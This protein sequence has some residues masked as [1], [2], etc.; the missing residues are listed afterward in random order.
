[1]TDQVTALASFFDW[2]V[3]PISGA[4]HHAIDQNIAWHGRIMVI[5]WSILLPLGALSARF[6]KVMPG[7]DW[8]QELDRR[9]W[10]NAHRILQ[11][12]GIALSCF[13]VLLVFQAAGF[14]TSLRT[15][16]SMLGW[17]LTM[18][19]V[20]Q[21]VSSWFRGTSGGPIAEGGLPVSPYASGDHYLM[22]PR[23][24]IFE[25]FH[26]SVGWL[27]IAAALVTTALGL[28]LVDA[29]RWMALAI[30]AWWIILIC[31]FALLQRLG[32]C[33][34]TY[35]AIWGPA[36]EHPGN[37]REP[38]GLGIRRGESLEAMRAKRAD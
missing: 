22:T 28:L 17:M 5:S 34:D 38:I 24:V 2:L 19:G 35:Q 3:L 18:L 11:Y 20:A 14:K 15:T 8:P 6:L 26:K 16:H 36:T 21:V 25:R 13:G 4:S 32:W 27:A 31:C 12:V 33:M 1:M 29:P 30:G 7:Q 9:T 37:L 23:R 10:W